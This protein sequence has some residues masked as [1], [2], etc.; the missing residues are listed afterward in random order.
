MKGDP[1]PITSYVRCAAADHAL[2]GLPADVAAFLV[3][4]LISNWL[5]VSGRE[6]AKWAA[7]ET[8]PL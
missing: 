2:A 1:P 5:L 4:L 3:G 8:A 6:L 7:R